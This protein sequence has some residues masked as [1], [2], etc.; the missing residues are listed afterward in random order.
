MP[1]LKWVTLAEAKY[2]MREIHEGTCGNHIG[3]QSLAFKALRQGYYCP[4]MNMDNMEY[5]RKCDK[6]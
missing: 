6:C 1:L 4:T 3:G 2:I 5:A